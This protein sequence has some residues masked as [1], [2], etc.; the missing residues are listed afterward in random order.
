MA[1][2]FPRRKPSTRDH[3]LAPRSVL[4]FNSRDKYRDPVSP[5]EL[6]TRTT[7]RGKKRRGRG[8]K[9][10]VVRGARGDFLIP[11]SAFQ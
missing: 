9:S 1:S 7:P 10:E 8:E 2:F 3:H 6:L 11:G 5:R 4:I